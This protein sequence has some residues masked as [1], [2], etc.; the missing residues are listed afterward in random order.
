MWRVLSEKCIARAK[1]KA[2]GAWG[3]RHELGVI[4]SD[5]EES[6]PR[7]P[8]ISRLPQR[9]M[10][11][12]S[13]ATGSPDRPPLGF[14]ADECAAPPGRGFLDVARN[15]THPC[16]MPVTDERSPRHRLL[17]PRPSSPGPFFSAL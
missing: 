8:Q 13:G 9:V 3:M 11:G 15:D 16:L 2:I 5:V 14:S 6:P 12:W 10:G 17:G 4:P 1:C 7:K